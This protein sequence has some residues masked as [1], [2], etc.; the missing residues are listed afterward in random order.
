MKRISVFFSFM[1]LQRID[2]KCNNQ[3]NKGKINFM[4]IDGIILFS[5]GVYSSR[6]EARAS[7]ALGQRERCWQTEKV[8]H[9]NT[10]Y[11]YS[12]F[13]RVNAESIN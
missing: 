8:A 3:K 7:V 4:S 12:F 10:G 6:A 1:D 5:G 9:H 2:K 11:A 13:W